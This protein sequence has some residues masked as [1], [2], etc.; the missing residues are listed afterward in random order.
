MKT[1]MKIDEIRK[2]GFEVLNKSLGPDGMIK[3]IQ[4][5]DSGSGDYTKERHK[6]LEKY[7]VDTIVKEIKNQ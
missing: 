7:N 1:K 5:F 2:I 6:W 3:F 4:Q